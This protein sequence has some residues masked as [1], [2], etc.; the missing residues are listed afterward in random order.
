MTCLLLNARKLLAPVALAATWIL[1]SMA[2]RAQAAAESTMTQGW[3]DSSGASGFPVDPGVLTQGANRVITWDG[4]NGIVVNSLVGADTFYNEG[5]WGQGTVTANVEA[6]LVWNGHE[7]TSTVQDFYVSP[8]A[9]GEF[10]NHA[11]GVGSVIAGY[12]PTADPNNYPYY[13]LGMAPLTTLSSGAIATNWYN[14]VDPVTGGTNTY[15]NVTAGTF[16]SAY[17]HYFTQSATH[18]L[19]YGGFSFQFSAPTDVINSSWGYDDPLGTDP[20]TMAADGFARANPLTTL[21]VAAG[22]STTASNPSDNVGGPASG[23]NSISVGAVGNYTYNDFS[24]V[25][26]F[27][28]RGPQDYYDPVNGVIPGVRA[29]VDIV[30]PGTSMVVA[31]Y[32]GQ[33]GGNGLS[34]STTTPDSLR[35]RKGLVH[36]R[37]GWHQLRRASRHRRGRPAQEHQLFDRRWRR[38]A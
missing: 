9:S 31:F 10:D 33:T 16:Y 34:L 1:C 38:L 37:G 25:A 14:A 20:L 23:Y 11:T 17:N 12:D 21:V 30:A 8:G 32:G 27:S 19:N 28:S 3:E 35:G 22:N 29:P 2:P 5:V 4:E 24:T 13:K 18:T 36:L 7:T 26:D 6:G 15:F